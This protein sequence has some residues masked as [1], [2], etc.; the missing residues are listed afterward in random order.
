MY[1][2]PPATYLLLGRLQALLL[3]QQ[4]VA[5][6]LDLSLTYVSM[7]VLGGFIPDPFVLER[8]QPRRQGL[9]QRRRLRWRGT[10]VHGSKLAGLVLNTNQSY[11][12]AQLANHRYPTRRALEG[13]IRPA[14]RSGSY[15]LSRLSN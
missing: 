8:L 7:Q 4:Q 5:E 12:V 2:H 10:R 11:L 6:P 13:A 1:T 14:G 15:R 3:R 9:R